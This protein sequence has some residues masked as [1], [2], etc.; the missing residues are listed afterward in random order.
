MTLVFSSPPWRAQWL[1]P[2]QLGSE[3]QVLV[4]YRQSFLTGSEGGQLFP[5][6]EVDALDLPL[7]T[8]QGLGMWEGLPIVLYELSEAPSIAG[9]NWLGLRQIMSSQLDTSYVEMLCMAAQVGTWATQHRFCSHCGIPLLAVTGERAMACPQCHNRYYPRISPCMIALVTRGDEVLLARS[10]RHAPGVFSTLA[11][12]VEPGETIEQCIAR[13]VLEEVGVQVTQ[14][15]YITSQS[16]PFPHS[17]MLGFHVQYLH[18]EIRLQPEEIEEARWF[19]LNALPNLPGPHT[20]ARH[21]I[22]CYLAER[23]GTTHPM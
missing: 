10:P 14:P 15:R 21:L 1:D 9:L 20:I 17:L 18:G 16:W 19:P 4:H 3:T 8:K 22:D 7:S 11:G 6:T 13:E 12:F 5:L 23:L 2:L